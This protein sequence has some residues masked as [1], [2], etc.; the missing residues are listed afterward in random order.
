MLKRVTKIL[1]FIHFQRLKLP[2]SSCGVFRM[3]CLQG[4]Q[5][6]GRWLECLTCGQDGPSWPIV[7]QVPRL[8]CW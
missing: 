6:L 4:L 1:I 5:A 8:A 2:H 3:A 7:G